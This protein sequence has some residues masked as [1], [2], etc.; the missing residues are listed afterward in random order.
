MKTEF[1]YTQAEIDAVV[2]RLGGT[3]KGAN[4]WQAKCPSHDD[5]KPSLSLSLNGGKLVWRCFAGCSQESV[6]EG[7]RDLL[8]SNIPDRDLHRLKV[9]ASQSPERDVDEERRIEFARQIW[10]DSGPVTDT[11]GQAYLKHRGISIDIPQSIRYH[12][13]LKHGPTGLLLPAVIGAVQGPDRSITAVQRIYIRQDGRGKAGINNAKLSLGK[14]GTG[15][16]R[17]GPATPAIGICEGLE[18]GLSAME[19]FGLPIWC[20][21]GAR[22]DQIELPDCVAEAQ[23]FGDNGDAGHAAAEKA[24]ERYASQGRQVLLRYPPEEFGDWNDVLVEQRGRAA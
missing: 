6:W 18:T 4:S 11:F 12:G 3:R 14:L 10:K 13:A 24:A 23:I 17:L 21:L 7:L 2:K 19:M 9:R 22:M 15:A 16:L 20:A 5:R 8:A 1:I